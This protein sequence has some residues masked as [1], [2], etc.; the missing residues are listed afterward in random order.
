MIYFKIIYLIYNFRTGSLYLLLPSTYFTY[1]PYP[2][3]IVFTLYIFK[4]INIFWIW[5][6][7]L[8]PRMPST[9]ISTDILCLTEL[10]FISL[11]QFYKS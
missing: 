5:R 7:I 3:Q 1:P 9:L 10:S 4:Y 8:S 11:T 6:G 2:K